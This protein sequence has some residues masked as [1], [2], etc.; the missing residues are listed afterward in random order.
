MSQITISSWEIGITEPDIE[1]LKK[2]SKLFGVSIDVLVENEFKKN[3]TEYR[4]G[5][6]IID[7][8]YLQKMSLSNFLKLLSVIYDI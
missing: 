2:L 5:K 7:T 3:V 6:V 1:N 8:E 4:D